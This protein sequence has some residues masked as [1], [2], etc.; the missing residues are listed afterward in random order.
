MSPVSRSVGANRIHH[1]C[2]HIYIHL[3]SYILGCYLTMTISSVCMTLV[4][5][6]LCMS[7]LNLHRCQIATFLWQFTPSEQSQLQVS[8]RKFIFSNPI[9][10]PSI[11]SV[12]IGF[13]IVRSDPPTVGSASHIPV[14]SI[15]SRWRRQ[16]TCPR[17]HTTTYIHLH[18][19]LFPRQ[20]HHHLK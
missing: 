6:D 10:I 3:L 12:P 17:R 13:V 2:S 4:C 11:T 18:S 16:P 8:C 7:S 5:M 1:R 14:Q 9:W 20:R 15:Q 19:H